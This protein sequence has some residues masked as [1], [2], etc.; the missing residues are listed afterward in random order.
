MLCCTRTLAAGVNLPARRVIFRSLKGWPEQLGGTSKWDA[1]LR[2]NDYRQMA[3]R[4]GRAGLADYG[5]SILVVALHLPCIS[6]ASPLYLPCISPGES[7]LVVAGARQRA[8]A[9]TL[10]ASATEPM[11]SCLSRDSE[12]GY[13]TL[14]LTLTLSLSLTPSLSLSLSLSLSPSLSLSLTLTLAARAAP[15][16]VARSRKSAGLSVAIRIDSA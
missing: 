13:L 16:R 3:G 4:A 2:V 14:T 11:R 10:L 9:T 12:G 8:A 7:I 15:S 1:L 5:E 6:P